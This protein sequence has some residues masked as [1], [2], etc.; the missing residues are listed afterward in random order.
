MDRAV[1][2]SLLSLA[3]FTGSYLSGCIPTWLSGRLHNTKYIGLF[4]AGLLVGV[5]LLIIIPESVHELYH[6]NF[7]SMKDKLPGIKLI[8][9]RNR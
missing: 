6:T 1:L 2:M 9:D 4:G 8:T 3:M 7:D 5:T